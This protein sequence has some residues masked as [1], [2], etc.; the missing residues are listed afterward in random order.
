MRSYL[1]PFRDTKPARRH[2]NLLVRE[3]RQELLIYDLTRH[4][5][6]CL[7]PNTAWIWT[8]CTGRR[9]AEALRAGLEKERGQP[10]PEAA[11]AVALQ[12]LSRA[13][14]LE[15]TVDPPAASL[16]SRRDML[17]TAA[18]FGGLAVLAM[19]VP[20]PIQAATCRRGTVT[21]AQCSPADPTSWGCCCTNGRTCQPSGACTGSC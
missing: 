17:R 15:E 19:A 3:L 8:H 6:F 2:E 9:T 16:R 18:V 5:A 14:L 13:G 20:T 12:R 7:G 4:K 10:V 1:T 21:P 11:I